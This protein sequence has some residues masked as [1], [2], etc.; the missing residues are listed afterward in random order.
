MST[1]QDGLTQIDESIKEVLEEASSSMVDT[2]EQVVPTK[3]RGKNILLTRKTPK[4]TTD[5]CMNEQCVKDREEYEKA[6]WEHMEEMTKLEEENSTLK[7][8]VEFLKSIIES[9]THMTLGKK[10]RR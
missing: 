6:D 10:A 7:K 2:K 5:L 4:W 9:F 3:K 1:E 8:E